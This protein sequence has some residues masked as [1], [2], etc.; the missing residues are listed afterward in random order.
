MPYVRSTIPSAELTSFTADK[1]MIMANNI[2]SDFTVSPQW[3]LSGSWASG[4]DITNSTFPVVRAFDGQA[5]GQTRPTIGASEVQVSFICDLTT[6]TDGPHTWDTAVIWGHNLATLGTNFNAE[7]TISD[8]NTFATDASTRTVAQWNGAGGFTT[9]RLVSTQLS[10]GSGVLN[11]RYTTVRYMRLRFITTTGFL[12]GAPGFGELWLGRR[13]Q[14]SYFP[15]TPWAE[16]NLQSDVT[17]F[18]SRSGS[19]TRYVRNRGQRIFEPTW[20]FDG[21]DANG[22]NQET[23]TRAW[24]NECRQGSR[25][26]VFF[27]SPSVA[28]PTAHVCYLDPP[29]M[30]MP[31]LGP[32]EREISMRFAES[33]PYVQSEL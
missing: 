33:A 1:P 23:E 6:G 7:L 4:A 14:M 21:A 32:F 11:Q 2:V 5:F 19:R 12:A 9:A 29:K 17:D 22:L 16:A 30:D 24:F 31:I 28:I 25:P 27:E 15:D 18:V 3:R 20:R 8:L 26:F 10:D 13:R